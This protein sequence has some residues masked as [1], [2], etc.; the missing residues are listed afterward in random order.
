MKKAEDIDEYISW[1]PENVQKIMQKIRATIKK[2]APEAK[3]T[4]NYAIPAFTLEGN[5][6]FFAAYKNHIGMYPRPRKDEALNKELASYK[7]GKGTIQFPL[8][9]PIPYALITKVV[10]YRVQ[11]NMEK[12]ALK[13]SLRRCKQ[14]HKYYKTS[15]CPT[16]P[17]CEKEQKPKEGFLA[18]LSAP[19]RR[20]LENQG[21]K[22]LKQLAKYREVEIL[23]LHGMGK[24]SIPKLKSALKSEGLS[25]KK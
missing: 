4:I 14:G 12:A 9:E 21:I 16:C 13:K 19:A 17:V 25:F 22:T 2:A 24:T 7:G 23:E 8:D 18:L 15:D 1:F 6:I 11:D 3:E 5:L 20:A 10:K